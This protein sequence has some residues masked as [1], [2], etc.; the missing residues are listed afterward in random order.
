MIEFNRLQYKMANKILPLMEWISGFG[1]M[2]ENIE[3]KQI[4]P[5]FKAYVICKEQKKK[6]FPSLE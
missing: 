6:H 3:A 2:N 5:E 1:K 4:S